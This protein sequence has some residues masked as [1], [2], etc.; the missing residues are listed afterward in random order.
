MLQS[1]RQQRVQPSHW[2]RPRFTIE[3]LPFDLGKKTGARNIIMN[4]KGN[5]PVLGT[6]G[7][8]KILRI[9]ALFQFFQDGAAL[10]DRLNQ[11]IS[12]AWKRFVDWGCPERYSDID[13]STNLESER[14]EMLEEKTEVSNRRIGAQQP[15]TDV[16]Q[17]TV[18]GL[19][20][21]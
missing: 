1:L 20:H 18:D 16:L 17:G 4:V 10:R 6:G 21:G 3:H 11:K 14:F 8:Q 15:E 19:I 13:Y 12:G 5:F 2:R 9:K 7:Y